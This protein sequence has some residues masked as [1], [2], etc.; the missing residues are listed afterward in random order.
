M[1][2]PEEAIPEESVS[3]PPRSVGPMAT[4][5][6]EI[7]YPEEEEDVT[8]TD[9]HL[10]W[11]FLLRENL[12]LLLGGPHCYVG[13]DIFWYPV[14]GRPDIKVS[15]DTLVVFGRPQG[16]RRTWQNWKE[17]GLGPQVTIEVLSVVNKEPRGRRI[18][19]DKVV[20]FEDHGVQEYIELDPEE[21]SIEV[22]L[23]TSAGLMPLGRQHHW[24]SERLGLTFKTDTGELKAFGPEGRPLLTLEDLANQATAEASRAGAEASRADLAEA[25]VARLT[26]ELQRLRD[27][28]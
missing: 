21:P 3:H 5:V 2:I 12:R 1:A 17:A 8:G 22:W 19:A 16:Q 26:A 7:Y 11:I 18:L 13:G 9:E 23:R 10:S 14:Q 27:R 15:P 6:D 4:V 25:E 24:Y 28:G 20:F